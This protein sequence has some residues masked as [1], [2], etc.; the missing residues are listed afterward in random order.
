M[1]STPTELFA[2]IDADDADAVR[3]I[4]DA[5]PGLAGARDADGVSAQLRARYRSDRAVIEAIRSVAPPLDVAEASA[6]GEVGRLDELLDAD[7]ARVAARS[8]DGFT[9]LH[10]A[11]F[12]GKGE[13]VDVLLA[14]GAEVDARGE[15]WM[16]GT[17]LHSAVSGRHADIV[18]ALLAAGADPNARQA[19]G[20]TPLHGA[21]HNGDARTVHALLAAGADPSAVN[22]EGRPVLS[23]AEEEGDAETVAAIRDALG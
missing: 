7:P 2:A 11:A 9:P 17:A 13:A 21:A 19:M 4:L 1:A 18:D 12:F 15:G 10:L 23:L 16:V 3:A 14:R 22:D 8:A 5:D 20:W 6:F